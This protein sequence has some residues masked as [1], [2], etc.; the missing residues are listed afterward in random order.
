MKILH[1]TGKFSDYFKETD[2]VTLEKDFLKVVLQ[3][4][5]SHHF[6]TGL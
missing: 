6:L 1:K 3:R 5:Y 2:A 4:Y